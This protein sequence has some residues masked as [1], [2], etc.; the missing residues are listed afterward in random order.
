MS[1]MRQAALIREFD[2]KRGVSIATLSYEYPS[3]F[4]VPE[5]AH[6]SDQ[7]IYAVRGLMEVHSAQSVW[8]MPPT[9]ALWVPA[10]TQHSIRMS[11]AVSMRTLYLRPGI[12]RR[13]DANCT[14]LSISPLLRELI[15]ETVQI[16]KLRSRTSDHCAL[17][18]L[19]AL[20]IARATSIPTQIRMPREHRALG[21][22]T[23][24]LNRLTEAPSLQILC[25]EVG[26]STRTLQRLFRNE[27]GVDADSWRQQVRLTRAIE[28][29]IAGKS[30]KQVAFAVGYSQPSAFVAAFRRVYGKTPK[31]WLGTIN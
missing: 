16:G 21:V 6:G 19:T 15:L 14:V 8:L 11:A 27:V 1:R 9:F 29:L 18:D 31:A 2:P 22:A 23:K 5:H 30:V 4:L 20:R 10:G 7:L 12:A 24:L 28:Y 17:R 25:K 3:G 26:V 13:E